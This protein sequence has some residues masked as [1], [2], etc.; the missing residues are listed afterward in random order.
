MIVLKT[1][2]R[3]E[4]HSIETCIVTD[5]NEN[6]IFIS[7]NLTDYYL[8]ERYQAYKIFDINAYYWCVF[9]KANAESAVISYMNRLNDGFHHIN[10][11]WI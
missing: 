11:L 9:T 7:K 3:L 4:F 5:D 1:L 6:F 8:H 2:M 10:R